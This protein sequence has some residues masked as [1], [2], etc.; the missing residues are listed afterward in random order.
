[1]LSLR[2]TAIA[3]LAASIPQV[4]ATP[5]ACLLACVSQE[6]KNSQCSG[7]ADLDCICTSLGE[8]VEK[9]LDSICPNGEADTAKLAFESSCKEQGYEVSGNSSGSSSASSSSFSSSSSSA[10]SSS[11]PASS[12]AASSSAASSS[13]SSASSAASSASS[14]AA[15]SSSVAAVSHESSEAASSS[16]ITSH[17]A[18]STLVTSSSGAASSSVAEVSSVE[19]GAKM[20]AAAF[21]AAVAGVVGA[22]L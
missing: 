18:S 7:L 3:A 14:S 9:C 16:S 6:E 1:M 2:F 15:A 8:D 13:A 11:D 5:P 21:G 17:A 12:S 19:G 22:L 4:L 20:N 10:A